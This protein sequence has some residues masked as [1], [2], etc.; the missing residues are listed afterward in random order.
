MRRLKNPA[1][2]I[3]LALICLS[4]PNANLIDVIPDF[5]AYSLIIIAIGKRSEA[6]PYLAE[7]KLAVERLALVSLI[8]I[9]AFTVMYSNMS[10]GKDIIPLF[11]IVFVTLEMILL[12]SA[13]QNGARGLT[14]IGERTNASVTVR[15]FRVGRKRSMTPEGLKIMTM[16]FLLAKG[17]LNLTPELLLLTPEDVEERK[18]LAEAYPAVL[19]ISILCALVIGAI[20]LSHALKYVRSIENSGELGPVLSSLTS[21]DAPEA[22]L[23]KNHEKKMKSSLTLVA[24]ASLFIFDIRFQNLGEGNI[25]PHFIYGIV[26]FFGVY[27]LTDDKKARIAVT[28]STCGFV[29]SS[30]IGH[31]LTNRFLTTY[32][33][34]NLSHSGI[35]KDAYLSIKVLAVIELVFVIAMLAAVSYS[36]VLFI[37]YNTDVAPN[38]PGYSETNM[39]NH[40]HTCRRVLPLFLLSA[41]INIFKCQNVF[42]KQNVVII[43]SEVNPDGVMTS[44][45]PAFGTAIFIMCLVYVIYSFYITSELKDEVKFKYDKE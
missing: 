29:I 20:W 5:I 13:V 34:L 4:N 16:I 35:A 18:R 44:S 21:I 26:L 36:F 25:L 11:T 45:A 9:P 1:F 33:Y 31:L 28:I 30:F 15:P 6:I 7:C 22:S 42:I 38:E 3:T 23:R 19:V 24:I 41:L 39:L 12:Y 8:K 43:P 37:R 40:A 32:S 14:Y 10:T 17:I 27:N 2:L